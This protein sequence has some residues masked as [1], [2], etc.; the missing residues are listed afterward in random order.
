MHAVA[1]AAFETVAV[2]QREEELEVLFLAVVR[3]GCHQQQVPGQAAQQLAEPIA[4]GVLDLATEEGGR[5]LVRLVEHHQIPTGLRRLQLGLDVLVARQLVQPRDHQR[6]FGEPVAG[7]CRLELVVG[8][9]LEGQLE[10]AP[11]FVLPLL[12]QT[13]G[14]DDQAAL[15]VT[16]GDQLLD[17]QA[18]HDRLARARVVRQQEAQRLP[19][20]HGIVDGG[21]LVRERVDQR[22]MDGEQRVEQMGKPYAVRLGHQAEGVPFSVEAPG[23]PGRDGFEPGLVVP[24]EQFIAEAAFGR[25]VGQFQAFRAEP[26]G[27]DD[28]D[29]GVRQ[30]A[31][32]GGA[33]GQFFEG[34]RDACLDADAP[35]DEPS[36]APY[37]APA[38]CNAAPTWAASGTGSITCTWSPCLMMS[39][40]ISVASAYGNFI[41]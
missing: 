17:Q 29:D 38:R 26:L 33:G 10:A 13:A 22:G 3:R 12:G 30:D 28:R 16:A 20:Q 4:L 8:E 5:Q 39:M 9:D 24:I 36:T 32:H 40:A 14:A 19:G 18:R 6:R 41:S 34:H 1:E 21:D 37:A 25:L 11:E 7:A 27:A 31:A 15:Q 35:E 23:A 2:Q